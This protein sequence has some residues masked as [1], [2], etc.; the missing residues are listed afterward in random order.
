MTVRARTAVPPAG[1]RPAVSVYADLRL[2][3]DGERAH[4]VADGTALVLHTDSPLRLWSTINRA[5]L[6][7]GVGRVNGPRALGRAAD[8]LAGAGL[9]VQVTGPSGTL[10]LLGNSADSTLGRV[11]TGSPA[12]EFGSVRVLASTLSA[13]VPVRR[14]G[15]AALV[16]VL[17]A[18][19]I[20]RR[21]RR[22]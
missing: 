15:L 16:A 11:A 21:L 14:Y 1:Q 10:V 5:A 18:W 20:A 22:R 6:P 8:L 4:L 7:S 9:S 3:S 2:D 12:V 13:Q 19:V 17:S